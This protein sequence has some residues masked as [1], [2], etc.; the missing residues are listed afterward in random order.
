MLP[1]PKAKRLLKLDKRYISPSC[2]RPYPAVI[3]RGRGCYVWDVD[4]NRFLDFVAGIAVVATGH[5]HPEIVKVIREQSKRLIHIS[6]TDF[7]YEVQVALAEKLAE[8]VPG[9]P[10]RKV[11]FTNSGTEAIE[12]AMKLARFKRR[13]PYFISF[14]NSFHGRTYGSLSL[15]ASKSIQR[16]GFGP[17]LPGVFHAPYGYCYRCSFNL[18]YPECD[19]ACLRF[20]EEEILKKSAPAEDVAAIFVEPIQGEGGYIV[21]PPGYFQVLKKICERYDILLVCDEIQSG[22]GRTGRMFGIEHWSV[23]PDIVCVAKGIASGLPLGATI[24]RSSMMDW[25]PGSHASTFGGN[26]IACACGLKTIELLEG[27]LIENAKVQGDYLL[28]LLKELQDRYEVIG[29]VRGKGLMVGVELVL[30]RIKKTPTTSKRDG[31][32]Y[33]CFQ[34]G[35]LCLG[36]GKTTVRFSPPL[37]VGKKEIDKAVAIFEEALKKVF[38]IS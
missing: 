36:A 24:A 7:Y 8:I 2:A 9:S 1:G 25:P 11:F 28:G 35:L 26:P 4:G 22:M 20:L 15:T 37:T 17:F 38:R 34:R 5:C 32:V 30:D 23:I 19:Y 10:N 13:R 12:C 21:P 6:G 27:G 3:E 16:Q 31:V 29:D 33:E 14:K 18:S